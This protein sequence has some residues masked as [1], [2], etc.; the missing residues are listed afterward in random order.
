MLLGRWNVDIVFMQP[1]PKYRTSK[2]LFKVD[3]E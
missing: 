3:T 1:V 2:W